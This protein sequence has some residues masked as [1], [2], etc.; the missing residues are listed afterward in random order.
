VAAEPSA[1]D[2]GWIAVE[3]VDDG[4]GMSEATRD[5]LFEPFFTTKVAGAGTGL[6][7]S[8]VYGIVTQAAGRVEVDSVPGRGSTFTVLL[9]VAT[10][11]RAE[12]ARA[13]PSGELHG[14]ERL[15]LVEDDPDVR[16]LARTVLVEQGYDVVDVDGPDAAL[17]LDPHEFD[18][19]IT[20]V[21]MPTM[22]GR[23]LAARMT[24]IHPGLR[25]VYVSAY[26]ST[27]MSVDDIA[28]ERFHFVAK[29][30]TPQGLAGT[31]RHVLDTDTP[32]AGR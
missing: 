6:G 2:S 17:A 12:P 16:G 11:Q 15:L 8:T 7:L 32:T 24:A 21:L 27:A 26:P 14:R 30:F 9:P 10:E 31:V 5:R 4:D 13:E 1:A 22:N 3:V 20:D 28:S 23:Q 18:L 29:P 19:L 25:V